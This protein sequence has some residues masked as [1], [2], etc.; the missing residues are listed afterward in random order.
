[1]L[2]V[3]EAIESRRSIRKFTTDD[4][5]DE[6]IEQL[7]EAAR[8]AP[9]GHNL[10]PWRFLVLRDKKIKKELRQLYM[11]QEDIEEAPVVFIGLVDMERFSPEAEKKH[12]QQFFELELYKDMTGKFADIKFQ[13]AM[14]DNPRPMTVEAQRAYG[15]A[16]VNIAI[17][18]IAL[19][20][21]AMGLGTCWKGAASNANDVRRICDLPESLSPCAILT[22]G[23]PAENPAP[24]P[25]Y[26]FDEIL[27]KPLPKSKK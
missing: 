18:H 21:T 15:M 12:M 26:S 13:Q 20:A 8:L 19:M 2:N 4:V 10:Q 17:E 3:W 25:R 24:R 6:I 22:L 9:S 23:Y 27:A 16:N 1:M 7:L 11:D 5:S 14:A